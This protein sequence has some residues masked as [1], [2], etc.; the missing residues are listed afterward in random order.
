MSA[1]AAGF[2]KASTEAIQ[3]D[4]EPVGGR[5]YQAGSR[6]AQ[7]TG[8]GH[9]P[10]PLLQTSDSQVGGLIETKQIQDLPLAA[11]DFMQLTLLAP[12]VV[13]STSNTRH[14]T[15]RGTWL[16]SFSVHGMTGKYNQYLFDGMSGKEMQHETNIFSPSIDAIQ[17]IKIETGNYDAEFGAEAGGHLNVVLKSGTNQLHGALYEF[18][19]NDVLNAKE[20]YADRKAELRR[21]TFGGTIGGPIKKDKTF[22]F[23]SWESMRLRQGFTQNSYRAH[24]GLSRG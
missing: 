5:G 24:G 3:L 8:G 14:Q 12:G 21:N 1:E 6:N 2:R 17:E 16:G 15:E 7:R 10:A 20:K 18:L 13:E 22:I 11:R 9:R 4:V 19:R 23:G